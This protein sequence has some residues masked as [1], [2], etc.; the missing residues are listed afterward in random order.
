MGQSHR[1]LI[2]WQ[3]AMDFVMDVYRTTKTFPRDETYALAG[4]LRRAA[5][6]VPTNIAEGQARFSP[7]EFY[8]FLGRARGSL[9]EVETQL[10]IAQNLSYFTPE[11]GKQLLERAAELGKI[12]NG[13]MSAIRPAA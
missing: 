10:M 11:H 12:L 4:Q 1:E 8:F 5:V 3:K 6:A 13:L 7:N 9:V 2:A